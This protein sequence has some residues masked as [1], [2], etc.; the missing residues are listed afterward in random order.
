MF[1][2]RNMT[3]TSDVGVHRQSEV[4]TVMWINNPS[5][6][7]QLS[8]KTLRASTIKPY[9]D[10]NLDIQLN[11]IDTN[12]FRLTNNDSQV[13]LT[14]TSKGSQIHFLR[15]LPTGATPDLTNEGYVFETVENQTI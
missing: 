6:G 5:N 7:P 1:N 14:L 4:N 9:S 2:D 10:K 15:G 13:L 11:T 8:L 12:N 3:A